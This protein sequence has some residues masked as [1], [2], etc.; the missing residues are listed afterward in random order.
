MPRRT[1]PM[2]QPAAVSEAYL[3]GRWFTA[4]RRAGFLAQLPPKEWHT[5]SALLSFTSR[6]GRRGFSLEQL[7]LA[8]GISNRDALERLQVLT[9]QRW[10]E[11]PLAVLETDRRGEI[12][13]VTLADLELFARATN[14]GDDTTAAAPVTNLGVEGKL[15]VELAAVGLD[16]AQIDRLISRFPAERIRRQLEGLPERQPRNPAA[17]LIRAIEQQWE[18]PREVR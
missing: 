10:Q 9:E 13:G 6:D 8:L 17:M 7:A 5:L 15:T 11:Q 4:A 16:A 14:A 1:H 2:N 12:V 3:L 18:P